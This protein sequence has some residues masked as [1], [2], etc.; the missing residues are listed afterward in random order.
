MNAAMSS[1]NR[2]LI[3]EDD[4]ISQRILESFLTKWGYEV[5]VAS[6]GNEAWNMLNSDDAPRLAVLDWMMPGLEGIQVCRNVRARV[7]RPYVYIILLT[8]RGLKQDLI[9]AMNAGADDYLTKPFDAEEL[10]ARVHVGQRI[11]QL[12]DDLIAARD[13]LR[14]QATHDALTNLVNRGVVL[15]VL[16]RETARQ[17]REGGALAVMLCDLDHFKDVNDRYGHQAGD[18]VLEEVAR[19]LAN[20]VRV[21]DTVGRYG[22]EEFLIVLPALDGVDA[23]NLA[24]RLRHTLES[25]PIPIPGGSLTVTVSLGV[26]AS[27]AQFPFEPSTLLHAADIALY[28]AKENGRNRS[29][30][31]TITD[32]AGVNTWPAGQLTPVRTR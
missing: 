30:I 8:A 26:A 15:E 6:N 22:G 13:E 25:H 18:A 20:T 16:L 1:G 32:Y 5:C 21:Y 3:A 10:R 17:K 9:E 19:R 27:S 14:F 24:E 29:E 23:L 28:R 31:A 4:H 11:I 12:Q 2:V 7:D